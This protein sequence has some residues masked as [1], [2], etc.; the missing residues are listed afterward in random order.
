MVTRH[1]KQEGAAR[2]LIGGLR[3]QGIS[4]GEIGRVLDVNRTTIWAFYNKGQVPKRKDIR[5][6]L[7]LEGD[8][9][10]IISIRHRRKDGTF[11]EGKNN[12]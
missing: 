11:A 5:Q 4:Y 12:A 3:D 2:A 6:K 10:M 8:A 7:G 9:E 1:Q